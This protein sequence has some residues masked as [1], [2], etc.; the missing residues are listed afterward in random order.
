LILDSILDG[1]L[2][3]EVK[4]QVQQQ[5]AFVVVSPYISLFVA[6]KKAGDLEYAEY[7]IFVDKCGCRE[8]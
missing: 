1:M 6:G 2:A 7:R 8:D 3:Y 4:S 5:K